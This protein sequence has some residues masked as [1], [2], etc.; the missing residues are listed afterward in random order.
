LGY[1]FDWWTPVEHIP[2]LL[3]GAWVT[4]WIT[5]LAFFIQFV[6]GALFGYIR[7][8]KKPRILYRILT[9]YIEIVRNTPLLVQ[10][11]IV[12]FG[13]PQLGIFFSNYTAG[14]LALTLNGCAYTTEIYRAGIQSIDKGQWEAGKCI[15]LSQMR[16][17]LDVISPQTLRNIFPALINQF[18]Y[19]MYMTTLLSALDVKELTQVTTIVATNTFRTFEMYTFAIVLYYILSG[20]ATLVLRKINVRFFPSVSR[21]G[22]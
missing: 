6:V 12:Y 13:L 2:D 5:L 22:E 21:K 15:G 1:F 9:I 8:R 17:F 7:F 20:L 3:Q 4:I 14:I 10:I 18:V 19:T 11:F 16:I